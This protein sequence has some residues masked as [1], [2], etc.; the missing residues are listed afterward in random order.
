MLI[1]FASDVLCCVC[2]VLFTK[3]NKILGP[4]SIVLV[5]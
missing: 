2:V 1:Q 5:A 3:G 4:F